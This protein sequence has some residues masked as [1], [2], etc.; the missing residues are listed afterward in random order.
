MLPESKGSGPVTLRPRPAS[1]LALAVS[2]LVLACGV[3]ISAEEITATA[4]SGGGVGVTTTLDDAASA[5]GMSGAAA[6][7]RALTV[8]AEI[9]TPGAQD[10]TA[11][12]AGTPDATTTPEPAVTVTPTP[13]PD[14]TP[15]A[16]GAATRSAAELTE[17][18]TAA[19]NQVR[20]R[21]GRGELQENATLAAAAE[22][23]ARY[24]AEGNFFAHDGLDG[25]TPQGRLVT[26]GYTGRFRGEAL[27]AGQSSGQ[28][29]VTTWLNSPAHAAIMLDQT[30]EEIGIG[31]F[32]SPGSFY[33]HYW[34][35]VVGAP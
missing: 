12:T 32:Y 11:M 30:A 20:V 33:G 17:E 25:S 7:D 4:Q 19:V 34:V 21:S 23:Y 8:P 35:L 26:A 16:N 28:T 1:W 24:M 14:T 22:T 6:L 18:A 13:D 29:A 9:A 27:A 15:G 2:A 3:P 5:S 31:Y 10:L